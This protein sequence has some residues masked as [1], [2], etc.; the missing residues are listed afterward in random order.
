METLT[1]H[2]NGK[3]F[4][5][6]GRLR[7]GSWNVGIFQLESGDLVHSF[8]TDTRVTKAVFSADGSQLFLSGA[9]KQQKKA[10]KKFGVVDSNMSCC[11]VC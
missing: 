11:V 7:G 8:K 4:A 10:D 5:M 9:N 3:Y 6:A 2:P 1:F